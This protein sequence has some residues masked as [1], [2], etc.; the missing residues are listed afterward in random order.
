MSRPAVRKT[1]GRLL[2]ACVGVWAVSTLPVEA[3]TMAGGSGHSVIV[4][5]DGTVWTVGLNNNGQLA[6]NTLTTR[7][8]PIQVSGLA[9]IVAVAA[10]AFHTLAVDSSGSLWAWGDN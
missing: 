5:P 7:K 4:K 10:G 8:T 2:L 9:N 3:Q 6:D 1:T